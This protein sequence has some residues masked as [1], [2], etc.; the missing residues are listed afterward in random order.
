MAKHNHQINKAIKDLI[1]TGLKIKD[2]GYH[3]YVYVGIN[4]KQVDKNTISLSHPALIDTIIMDVVI[5]GH[6]MIKPVPAHSS[7]ILQYFTESPD[8][9]GNYH[10]RQ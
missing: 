3:P 9:D 1:S 10:Y 8:F 6:T 5:G 4:I 2:Q 7:K